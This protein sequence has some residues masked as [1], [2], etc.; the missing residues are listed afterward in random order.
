MKILLLI[1]LLLLLAGCQTIDTIDQTNAQEAD[2]AVSYSV[3]QEAGE[4]MSTSAFLT[5]LDA[6]G[7]SF[8]EIW[9]RDAIDSVL[10]VGFRVIGIGDEHEQVSIYE[11]DS[12]DAM[13]QDSGL[14][15]A[16]GL[17]IRQPNYILRDSETQPVYWFK[18][19]LII[20]RH[21]GRN[22][23]IR[24]FL[25]EHLEF[26]AGHGHPSHDPDE[27]P[28]PYRVRAR[29]IG[30]NATSKNVRVIS[31]GN[32]YAG[33]EH[34]NHGW[35]YDGEESTIHASGEHLKVDFIAYSL[36]PFPFE[37]DFQIVF[38]EQPVNNNAIYYFHRLSGGDAWRKVLAVYIREGELEYIFRTRSVN[39]E[40]WEQV[41][42]EC[43]LD[44]L[45]P[46]EYILDVSAWWG[47]AQGASS[48]QN[49]FRFIK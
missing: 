30:P 40:N 8:E 31:A 17:S 36:I 5:L 38:V 1:L 20:I 34:W 25:M 2:D 13:E 26:F 15:S 3:V 7:F 41:Y 16:D 11:Y 14:V 23:G 44:L 6:N 48:L 12:N 46:G 29:D 27:T 47:D 49:F 24:N 10:S 28:P 21:I 32:E 37:E 18:S 43:F 22:E 42:A 33:V 19:D 35:F 45:E 39:R 9:E 4:P